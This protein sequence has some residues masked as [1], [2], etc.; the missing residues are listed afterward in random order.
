[1]DDAEVMKLQ[2]NTTIA[3]IEN[4]SDVLK[5]ALLLSVEEEGGVLTLTKEDVELL[6]KSLE[7]TMKGLADKDKEDIKKQNN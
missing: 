1:M 3:S 2:Y 6:A 5:E 7:E 4:Y